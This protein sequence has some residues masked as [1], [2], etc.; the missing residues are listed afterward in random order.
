MSA[1]VLLSVLFAAAEPQGVVIERATISWSELERLLKRE[2]ATAP[3]PPA[4][5]PLAHS[6][7]NLEVSGEINGVRA[8]IRCKF[9]IEILARNWAVVP[10]LPGNFALSSGKVETDGGR[11]GILVRDANGV[12]LVAK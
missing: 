9:E 10:I 12:A 8:N 7:S 5:A 1:A 2:G 6:I 4:Q 11:R 3:K